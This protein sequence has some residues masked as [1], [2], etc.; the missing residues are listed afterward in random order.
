MFSKDT[1]FITSQGI[2]T[3]EDFLI[4]QT[5]E[6]MDKDCMWRQGT[7][8]CEPGK[9]LIKVELKVAYKDQESE[10]PEDHL[11]ITCSTDQHWIL[12]DGRVTKQIA[13]GSR[14]YPYQKIDKSRDYHMSTTETKLKYK[15][16]WTVISITPMN[17]SNVEG[18]VVR[19]PITNSFCLEKNVVTSDH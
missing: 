16:S 3:F 11:I 4:G 15:G 14:L 13:V 9:S 6:I 19:E 17:Q 8:D 5:V 7:I 18:W 10:D 12:N 2:K 1:K